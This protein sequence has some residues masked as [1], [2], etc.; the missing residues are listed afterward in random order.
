MLQNFRMK[1][2]EQGTVVFK[3]MSF[4][5]ITVSM[6]VAHIFFIW[7]STKISLFPGQEVLH[8]IVSTCAQIIAGLYGITM[9]GYTFFLSRM[10][11]LMASDTTL[12]YIVASVKRRFKYLIWFITLNVLMVLFISIFLMY[13]HVP[14]AS[15]HAFFY[16]L[17]CNEF[18][19]S[20]AFSIILIL[21]YSIL[22]VDPNCLEKEAA[23]LKKK[24]SRP[25]GLPGNTAEF[26]ALYDRIE[27]KCNSLLPASVLS[28]IHEN[29]GK[30]FEFTI[31]LFSRQ[32]IL[33]APLIHDLNRIHRYYECVVNCS[34]MTVTKEMCLLAKHTLALLEQ[35][36]LP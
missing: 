16:R 36:M 7:L 17:F 10:D 18:V 26:V 20:L 5:V 27:T 4:Y 30:R 9:A 25:I 19:L 35:K 3:V 1:A 12:D 2:V 6:I 34:P 22:V 21:Y 15:S 24:L 23:K 14:T 29:K 33:P 28:Q 31:E 8:S 13:C 32:N 11:A